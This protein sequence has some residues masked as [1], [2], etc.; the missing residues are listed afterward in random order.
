MHRNVLILH[1]VYVS[2]FVS[3]L[4]KFRKEGLFWGEIRVDSLNFVAVRNSKA[5]TKVI[6]NATILN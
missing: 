6:K 3:H 4:T 5:M 2:M 1:R